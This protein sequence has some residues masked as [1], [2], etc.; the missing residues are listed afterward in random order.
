MKGSIGLGRVIAADGVLQV[1]GAGKAGGH[2][3][4]D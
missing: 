2:G 1:V 4:P 3:F